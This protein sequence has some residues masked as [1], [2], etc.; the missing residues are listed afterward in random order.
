MGRNHHEEQCLLTSD[1]IQDVTHRVVCVI[2]REESGSCKT[3][4]EG[5]R[6]VDK[7]KSLR[8]KPR[9]FLRNR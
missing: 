8:K 2:L 5:S 7:A 9:I 4:D 3:E 1:D 6:I